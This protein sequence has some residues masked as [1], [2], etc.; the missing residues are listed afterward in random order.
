MSEMSQ[1]NS[2]PA[3]RPFSRTLRYL[4]PNVVT[5]LS[6]LCAVFAMQAALRGEIVVACW[7][8]AYSTLTDK[9]DGIVARALKA[10]SPTR[11]A[12][13]MP[14]CSKSTGR[15]LEPNSSAM[16]GWR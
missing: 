12:Q 3:R 14:S 10:S 15:S 8:V 6:M 4:A 11:K 13:S 5:C 9:L 2:P 7:W 1:L 16:P